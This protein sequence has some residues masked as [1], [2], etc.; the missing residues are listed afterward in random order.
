MTETSKIKLCLILLA[1]VQGGNERFLLNLVNK[2]SR[3]KFN[4]LFILF[5]QE[6]EYA[7]LIPK[8]ISVVS[9]NMRI[10]GPQELTN[11]YYIFKL[12]NLFREF[13]P[14]V[15]FCTSGY[16]NLLTILAQKISG[17]NCALIIREIVL[18]FR[19]LKE[20]KWFNFKKFIYR[21]IYPHVNLVVAP[22]PDIF[23]D[24][25]Q[26]IHLRDNQFKVIPNFINET[27]LNERLSHDG[28]LQDF[29]L[30]TDKPVIISV[31]RLELYK[32]IDTALKA[33][34]KIMKKNSCYYW[35]IGKGSEEKRLKQMT[36]DLG[37]ENTVSFLGYQEN[38][39]SFLKH[40]DIFFL[41]SRMEGFPNALLEA[42][43]CGIPCL[44]TRYDHYI[45]Q[46]VTHN[47]CGMLADVDAPQEMAE[48]LEKLL[49]NPDLRRKMG[50]SGQEKIRLNYVDTAIVR[51]YENTFIELARQIP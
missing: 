28:G 3:E 44:V 42:L 8:D 11:P 13:K 25:K 12:A 21:I 26:N 41:P 33:I 34:S 32:G 40:A 46:F 14:Q 29:G 27:F 48:A 24:L 38:P 5:N 15:I 36:K 51:E 2:L 49:L 7:H 22:S 20:D 47:Q 18:R 6:G 9:L 43:Y 4:I 50:E 16:P 23:S 1:P 19:Y 30:K 37:L 31:T 35:I 10:P 17:I 45:E 39:Y